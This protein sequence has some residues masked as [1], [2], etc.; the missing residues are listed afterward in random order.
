ML[1]SDGGSVN[2]ASTGYG[3]AGC[4]RQQDINGAGACDQAFVIG[5]NNKLTLQA[6]DALYVSVNR[7]TTDAGIGMLLSAGQMFPTSVSALAVYVGPLLF[8]DAGI[9]SIG[10]MPDGGEYSGGVVT[11][12]PAVGATS[13]RLNVYTRAGTE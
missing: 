4:S 10:G 2:N 13:A 11:I 6:V 5:A 7:T 9:R 3:T 12:S 1:V 8:P